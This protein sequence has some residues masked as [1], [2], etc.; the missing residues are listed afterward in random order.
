MKNEIKQLRKC[1]NPKCENLT[2]NKFYCNY[3]CQQIDLA[4]R[5]KLESVKKF[6]ESKIIIS[7]DS[8]LHKCK[9]SNCNIL[10][11]NIPIIKY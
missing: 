2:T 10:T 11:K 4:R 9:R 1:E 6:K 8:N 5:S 3:K 7:N